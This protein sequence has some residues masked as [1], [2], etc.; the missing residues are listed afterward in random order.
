MRVFFASVIAAIVLA[1]GALFALDTTQRTSGAVF[2]TEGARINP[3][4]TERG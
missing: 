3:S 4:W 2:T 1:A